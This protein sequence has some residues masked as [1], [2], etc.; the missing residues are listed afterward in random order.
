MLDPVAGSTYNRAI[1]VEHVLRERASSV[2][3]FLNPRSA[4]L[5]LGLSIG[6]SFAMV[7]HWVAWTIR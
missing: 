2:F 4:D 6:L 1:V 5:V 3:Q 7:C